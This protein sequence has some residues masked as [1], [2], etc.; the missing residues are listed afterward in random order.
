MTFLN[1]LRLIFLCTTIFATGEFEKQIDLLS[2]GV[3]SLSE[4]PMTQLIQIKSNLIED[5]GK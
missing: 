5:I 1:K 2:N 3:R 4:L